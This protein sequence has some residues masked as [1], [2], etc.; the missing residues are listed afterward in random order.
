[1]GCFDARGE[2]LGADDF[3]FGFATVSVFSDRTNA[4]PALSGLTL[5]GTAIQ[6]SDGIQ[7]DHCTEPNIDDCPSLK[8]SAVVEDSAQELDPGATDVNGGTQKEEI[9]VDYYLTGG[10]VAHDTIVIFDPQGGRLEDLGNELRAPSAAGSYHLWAVLHDSRGGV[11]W[12]D[13]P[14]VAR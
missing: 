3:V 10:K 14:F 13:V 6:P 12:M 8:L 11:D 1:V 2:P 7:M 4:N 5:S 9:W